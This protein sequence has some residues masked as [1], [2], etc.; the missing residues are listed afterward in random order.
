[1]TSGICDFNSVTEH[2][3]SLSAKLLYCLCV[4]IPPRDVGYI[5]QGS[6]GQF[7]FNFLG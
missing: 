7:L 2:I 6:A 3:F 1:M 5:I 4:K